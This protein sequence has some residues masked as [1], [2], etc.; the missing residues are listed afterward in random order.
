M[1]SEQEPLPNVLLVGHHC[2]E[3]RPNVIIVTHVFV[4]LL[5]PDQLSVAIFLCLCSDQVKR[6]RRDLR[7]GGRRI[8]GG[9]NDDIASLSFHGMHRQR[10]GIKHLLKSDNGDV[11]L[12]FVLF[13]L[14]SQF[15]VDFASA[16]D[17]PLHLGWVLTRRALVRNQPLE[18]SACRH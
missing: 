14:S 7:G 2:E 18:F 15:I 10:R 8:S 6:E 13:P 17:H 9:R 4:L 16:E 11:S 12:Q 5:T 1:T 3:T